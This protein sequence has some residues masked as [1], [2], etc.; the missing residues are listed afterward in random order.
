MV[1]IFM[2]STHLIFNITFK[3]IIKI[4]RLLL[5]AHQKTIKERRNLKKERKFAKEFFKRLGFIHSK[6]IK[7][8]KR[9]C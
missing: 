2:K 7:I 4:I 5:D 3:T 6:N 8:Y 1:I 9:Y